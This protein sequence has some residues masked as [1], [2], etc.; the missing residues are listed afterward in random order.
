[1]CVV[2]AANVLVRVGKDGRIAEIHVGV[3]PETAADGATLRAHTLLP[4]FGAPLKYI[5]FVGQCN[6]ILLLTTWP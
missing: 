5:N 3:S 1:M 2:F 4:G 6:C